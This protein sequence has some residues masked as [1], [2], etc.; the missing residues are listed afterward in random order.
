MDRV[1][2]RCSAGVVV[3]M[4]VM[5]VGLVS[6][7]AAAGAA[8]MIQRSPNPGGGNDA[9]YGVS[10]TST[11]ACIAVGYGTSAFAE[12]WD[13]RRWSTQRV[14]RVDGGSELTS[15]SCTSPSACTAVGYNVCCT[16]LV[17]R[18]N[19]IRWSIQR[20][21]ALATVTASAFASVSCASAEV[22]TAVGYQ[23]H[24]RAGHHTQQT[25]LVER[26]KVSVWLHQRTPNSHSPGV[27]A[28][29]LTGVSCTSPTACTAVGSAATFAAQPSFDSFPRAER[30]NGKAWSIERPPYPPSPLGSEPAYRGG[31]LNGVSCRSTRAC[32]AVGVG[33]CYALTGGGYGEG[34]LAEGWNGL[35]WAI[36]P[37]PPGSGA[38]L[39]M[40]D[41]SC[42]SAGSC[43]AVGDGGTVWRLSGRSWSIQ[44]TPVV[45]EAT[46]SGVSCIATECFAVGAT[47]SGTLIERYSEP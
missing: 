31:L 46:L 37:T 16:P 7:Q 25:P 4:V 23:S 38:Y 21:P 5:A 2:C 19:G 3:A 34:T 17:V 27:V 42:T 10:C 41:V 33:C 9:L 18:W 6:A 14:A 32:T 39:G 1:T 22:C 40:T 43:T 15:V 44:P 24:S 29:S 11:R 26:W 12:R 8:W 45:S 35:N 30:W 47:P 36:Q 28:A 20:T 13:G